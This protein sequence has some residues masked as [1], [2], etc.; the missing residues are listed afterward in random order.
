[1]SRIDSHQHFWIYQAERDTWI[2]DQESIL[3]DDFMPEHLLPIL[4]HYGFEGCVVV[5]ADQS[6]EETLFQLKNAEEHSF[7]KGVVGWVD[8]QAKD[9]EDK[10]A[11]YQGYDKLKGFRHILQGEQDRALM[12]RPAFKKGIELLGKYG[13]TYDILV[14]SDQLEYAEILVAEFPDQPFVLDHLGKP[15]IK[16][17]KISD[18]SRGIRALARHENLYCKASGMVTEADLNNWK[19]TDFK[20]YLDVL[21]EAFG[22][23]RVMFGSDWPVCRLAAT[24]GQVTGLM[25][26]Y[27]SSFSKQEQ[28]QFWSGNAVRFYKL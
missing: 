22:T 10:L 2:S 1:M 28:E 15:D 3:K 21:F 27:I 14:F 24:Y 6:D 5:Q 9:L 19:A 23:G 12:L 4:V 17:G 16:N 13:Y 25:E 8:L 20:P 11:G 26:D 7:I 18:W